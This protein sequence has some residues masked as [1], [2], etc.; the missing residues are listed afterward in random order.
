[1]G[2]EVGRGLL[3]FD[4]ADPQTA[5]TL[6]SCAQA[7][8]ALAGR[9]LMAMVEPFVSHRVD[10]AVRNDLTPDAMVKAIS[11]ASGLGTTSA[12][13]WLKV[14]VVEDMERVMAA[15]SLPAVLLGG[16]VAAV[17]DA[18][19][20]TWREALKRPTVKRIAAGLALLYPPDGDRATAG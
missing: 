4:R 11:I 2:F 9:R 20:G 3:G 1:M 17:P 6:A 15:S 10:G 13:T 16:E 7:I 8:S 14:P 18:M 19:F 5:G 12:Y